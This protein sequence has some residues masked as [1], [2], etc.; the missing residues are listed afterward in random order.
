MHIPFEMLYHY[1]QKLSSTVIT[2]VHKITM[3]NKG[4]G[5][6]DAFFLIFC[7]GLRIKNHINNEEIFGINIDKNNQTNFIPITINIISSVL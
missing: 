2:W 4:I 5:R 3:P 7:E 1:S 6:F